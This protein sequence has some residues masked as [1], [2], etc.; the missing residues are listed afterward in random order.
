MDIEKL[1]LPKR[2]CNSLRKYGIN[3]IEQLES[4]E[5]MFDLY[6]HV[7]G[8]GEESLQEIEYKLKMFRFGKNLVVNDGEC[9]CYET[10]HKHSYYEKWNVCECGFNNVKKAKYCGGCGKRIVVA[11]V[12]EKIL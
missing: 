1:N 6:C 4:V 7:K 10:D 3:T 2:I 11:G 5:N 12:T 9:I 8:I